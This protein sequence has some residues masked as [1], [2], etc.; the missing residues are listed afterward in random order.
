[1][2]KNVSKKKIANPSIYP[3]VTHGFINFMFIF[4]QKLEKTKYGVWSEKNY[5]ITS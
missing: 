1:M 4:G 2:K 3:S 5:V